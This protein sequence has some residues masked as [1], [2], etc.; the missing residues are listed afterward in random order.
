M[1]A[2][3]Y[4]SN[5]LSY[6]SFIIAM[7]ACSHVASILFKNVLLHSNSLKCLGALMNELSVPEGSSS[8]ILLCFIGT[9]VDPF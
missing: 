2:R 9:Y 5:S 8:H 4:I 1:H 7:H 6:F 3:P